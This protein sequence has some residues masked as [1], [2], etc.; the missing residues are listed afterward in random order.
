M[1]FRKITILVTLLAIGVNMS[2]RDE[3]LYPL[4]YN[5]RTFG[6][7]LRMYSVTTNVLD[8]NNTTMAGFETTFEAVDKN[9]GN[10]LESVDF[11]V[12]FRN[13]SGLTDEAFIKSV[14]ASVFSNVSGATIST[15][16]RGTIRVT[17]GEIQA[18]LT[19][20]PI[21]SP[22]ANSQWPSLAFRI[23]YPG[24]IAAGN[25]VVLRWV[26]KLSNGQAFTVQNP[27]GT[28]PNEANSTSNITGGQFYSSPYQFTMTARA[29]D[30]G[31][32]NA[33]TGTYR[34]EQFSLWSPSHSVSLHR[35]AYP[36][37]LNETLFQ[38][39]QTVTLSIPTSGLSTEREFTVN[40][41]GGNTTMRI[42]LETSDPLAGNSAANINA[43]MTTLGI[44]NARPR[45]SVF[46]R[47]QKSSVNCSASREIY[48][49]T[50]T[51]GLFGSTARGNNPAGD[52]ATATEPAIP[53]LTAGLPQGVTPG[54]GVFF[55]N[56]TNIGEPA[57]TTVGDV[58]F[59]SVDDDCDEYGRRQGYCSW[60]RRVYLK[61]TKL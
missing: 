43:S 35:S 57:G 47:L 3:S 44:S 51:A 10:L 32:L 6:A 37:H 40:Y 52:P 48:W 49:V 22:P 19:A 24:S 15:Y 33:F 14:P 56:R 16:K 1:K 21:T 61:L 18:A 34:L 13:A 9:N 41:R 28:N 27:Q 46:V 45:G 7:Y 39:D 36:G 30:G 8:V 23:D 42:N 59:I 54:R 11:Y 29:L 50:P 53:A 17:Y 12:S 55:T 4:P 2:C 38:K 20:L 26:Q 60:T 31:D 5:D 58:F 25:Q